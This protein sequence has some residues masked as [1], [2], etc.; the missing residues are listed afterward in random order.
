MSAIFIKPLASVNTF[1]E[2]RF[3]TFIKAQH[4]SGRRN[5]LLGATFIVKVRI[6]KQLSGIFYKI[7]DSDGL[8]CAASHKACLAKNVKRHSLRSISKCEG[9]KARPS[10]QYLI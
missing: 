9:L 3:L 5:S 6:K 4:H 10:G 7:G 2:H 1:E 8:V